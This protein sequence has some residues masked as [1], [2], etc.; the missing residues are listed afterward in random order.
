MGAMS[1]TICTIQTPKAS[2]NRETKAGIESS[3]SFVSIRLTQRRRRVLSVK[4]LLCGAIVATFIWFG[5][6]T[7]HADVV[8]D[9]NA[10]MQETV[11]RT[12]PFLKI[13][14]AAIMH[15]AVFEAVNAI[16]RDYEPYIGRVT[17]PSGASPEAAAIAAA[18]RA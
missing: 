18:H 17:A 11:E 3:I 14:S 4:K 10:I 6:D 13:R 5:A 15:L 1:T 2:I 9:W 12:D 8:T 16:V 7:A